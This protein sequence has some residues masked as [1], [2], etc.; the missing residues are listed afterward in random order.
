MILDDGGDATLLVHLGVECERDATVPDLG[1]ED[2]E[3]FGLILATLNRT[4]RDDSKLW[5]ARRRHQRGTEE[6]T[7]SAPLYQ[8]TQRHTAVPGDQ[9][10]RLGDQIEVRQPLRLP[11]F[12]HRRIFRATM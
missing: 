9:R 3:E 2:S 6:T 8:R 4:L 10:E 7:R 11:P 12:A 1:P 5:T